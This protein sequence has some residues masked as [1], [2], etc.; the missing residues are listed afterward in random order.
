MPLTNVT[1]R[2]RN[3]LPWQRRPGPKRW[4]N[5]SRRNS[6][7]FQGDGPWSRQLLRRSLRADNLAHLHFSTG[8]GLLTCWALGGNRGLQARL[9]AGALLRLPL[10]PQV[11]SQAA[12]CMPAS[13]S[14]AASRRRSLGQEADQC[15]FS[16][17][18]KTNARR[19]RWERSHKSTMSS[20]LP[21]HCKQWCLNRSHMAPGGFSQ[22][23]G[24]EG[25]KPEDVL[26][27]ASSLSWTLSSSTEG[28]KR[29]PRTPGEGL[30]EWGGNAPIGPG[31]HEST[32]TAT[33]SAGRVHGDR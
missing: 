1:R 14:E 24:R 31:C 20:S 9:A 12:P 17:E 11:R 13:A 3:L 16:L 5:V 4:P 2:I 26:L 15:P 28:H 6:G 30:G 25:G 18:R 22:E 27:A 32:R 19:K 23:Q 29:P 33:E 10:P 21:L 7:A 8:S